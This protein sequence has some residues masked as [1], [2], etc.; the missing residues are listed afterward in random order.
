MKGR[1]I[2]RNWRV[3]PRA[4]PW[5]MDKTQKCIGVSHSLS[6]TLARFQILSVNDFRTLSISEAFWAAGHPHSDPVRC[7]SLFLP[8]S[9]EVI[10]SKADEWVAAEPQPPNPIF[11]LT[12]QASSPNVYI[13]PF[14]HQAPLVMEGSDIRVTSH[15]II[16]HPPGGLGSGTRSGLET[17]ISRSRTEH[18]QSPAPYFPASNQMIFYGRTGWNPLQVL[19]SLAFPI[20]NTGTQEEEPRES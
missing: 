7:T 16:Q 10:C 8:F 12:P 9:H 4:R 13:V 20:R 1:H 18:T 11:K 17:D 15:P 19:P 14:G 2:T 6:A 3:S 5:K